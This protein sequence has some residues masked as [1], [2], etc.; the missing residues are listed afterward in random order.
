MCLRGGAAF[1]RTP[2]WK[3]LGGRRY[4][5]TLDFRGLLHSPMNEQGVVFLFATLAVELGF[6]VESLSTDFPDCEAKRRVGNGW[7]RVRIE[8]E[9]ESRNF[10]RHR[11]DPK[12]CDLIVCWEHNWE[13]S[14]IE[15]LALKLLVMGRASPSA[16]P[17]PP[18]EAPRFASAEWGERVP[19]SAKR[20]A[21]AR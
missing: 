15:V 6:L 1:S 17:S 5:E 14:P 11:H 19:S 21:F 10:R 12:A 3:T 2:V 9:Y 4:G 16:L 20:A 7:E 13:K 8:F 18:T